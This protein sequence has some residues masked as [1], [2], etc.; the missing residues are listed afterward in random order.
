VVTLHD[1]TPVVLSSDAFEAWRDPSM[2]DVHTLLA[3][4]S[5]NSIYHGSVNLS[6]HIVRS[7]DPS[8]TE[9]VLETLAEL[10]KG[11]ALGLF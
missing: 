10:A 3:K 5:T 4:A 6:A 8:L 7:D 9:R 2:K 11:K 1:R